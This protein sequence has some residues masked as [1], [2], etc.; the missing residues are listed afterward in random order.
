VS[1]GGAKILVRAGRACCVERELLFGISPG[2]ATSA[3]AKSTAVTWRTM[4][5]DELSFVPS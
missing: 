3:C 2:Q 4:K 1:G 5:R